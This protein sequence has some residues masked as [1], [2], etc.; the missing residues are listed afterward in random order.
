MKFSRKITL[1]L[2]LLLFGAS[3]HLQAQ[4]ETWNWYFGANAGVTF[5]SGSPV[6]LTNGMINTIEGVAS[7][8]DVN[9]NLLFYTDGITVW[10]RNHVVM[11]NGT[12]LMGSG[13]SSQS[14]VI[15][16]R[17]GSTTLYYIF[18][19][20]AQAGPG[21]FRYTEVDMALSGGFGSVTTKNNLL[22][23]VTD[24]K[25]CAV[26]HCNNKDVWV[27]SHDFNSSQFRV[28]LVTA[29]GIN[30][31]PVLTSVGSIHNGSSSNTLGYMKSSSDG[32]R[33]ALST[34]TAGFLELF[35]FNPTTGVPSNPITFTSANY[36]GCYGM[37][38]SPDNTKLYAANFNTKVIW[39]FDLCAGSSTAI[40]NSATSLGTFPNNMG[41]LQLGPDKKIYCARYPVSWLGV[42]NSPNTLG[43]GCNYV[44]NGV[45]LAGKLSQAGLPNFIQSYF[46]IVPPFTTVINCLNVNFTAPAVN[47]SSCSGSSTAITGLSWNFG[48]PN[49]GGSNTATTNTSSHTFTSAGTFSVTLVLNYACGSDTIKQNVTVT[50]CGITVTAPG[51]SVCS[52]GCKTI[53]ATVSAGT[54]PYTYTWNTGATTQSINP[55]P[56]V[57]TS[58]T[59]SVTDANGATASAIATLTVSPPMNIVTSVI[60]VKCNGGATGSASA[61][62]TGGTSPYTYSW[63]GNSSTTTSA[64]G[65]VQ[66]G[67]TFTVTDAIGCTK[68][69][70]VNITQPP[71]LT[72]TA[73]PTNVSCFGGSNG[74]AS[75][76]ANGGTPNY[77]YSWSPS[78]STLSSISGLTICGVTVTVTDANGC[79][80][81]ATA[82]ITQP[83]ALVVNTSS[84]PAT[85]STGGTGT[86]T[87]SGGTGAYTYLWSSG[88]QTTQTATNLAT[89]THTITVTDA[90]G[91]TQ[92]GTVNITGI[93][94]PSVNV[95]GT[96]VLCNG[97]TTGTASVTASGGTGTMTYLWSFGAQTTQTAT[98]LPQG[99]YTVTV[100]DGNGCTAT[101]TVLITEPTALVATATGSSAC[102]NATATGSAAGGTGTYTY[103]WNGTSQNTQNATG[104]N[105]GIYTLTV[106][107]ANGCSSQDTAIITVSPPP[108]VSFTTN[109]S[110]GCVA[111]CINL[112]CTSANIS[113]YT[114][115]FGDGSSNGNGST[116]SHC[117]KT[118]GTFSVTL[119]VVDNSGCP[120]S[121]TKNNYINV[122]PNVIA[123]FTAGPQPTTILNPTIQFTDQSLNGAISWNWTF[124]DLLN[125]VSTKQNPSFPYKD[126]GCYN[127][128]LIA[129]NQYNCPDT[130][131]QMVCIGGD[132]ELFAPNA[133][134]PDGN[135]L[136]DLFLP[137]GIG[138]DPQHFEMYIF[139]RWGNLIFKTTDLTEGWNGKAN[140]GRDI[141]QQ[142]VYVW[143]VNTRD[144]QGG[145][146]SYTGHVSLVR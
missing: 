25:C 28:Y 135:G 113:S 142:D 41:A 77:T 45:P 129:D 3:M 62:I 108:V 4:K 51:G 124:G 105:T 53:T 96:N 80:A 104:L 24:E 145:K 71:A 119:S 39:Q 15:V 83:P 123:A 61:T 58:Y 31:T 37:E 132:Y 79:T 107:D 40:I 93:S 65:L 111:L 70:S 32:K 139:D 27:L 12:G 9:G 48:D 127:V 66:G 122:Y 60:N 134:T 130:S 117:Y 1:F 91:C 109:D 85:C 131:D 101:A 112:T 78:G 99:T 74:A 106:T 143:K 17:P 95:S 30:L 73:T 137:R 128:R 140:G 23:G 133:F 120:G 2:S 49:S 116:V 63:S 29:A 89:G 11:T 126:S 26:R 38:F 110:A 35:D 92:T 43:L 144:F 97:G 72:V 138:I 20:D 8:S 54:S 52:G 67:Y 18:T 47:Q 68:T 90:N 82:T 7:I 84:T 81:T 87:V 114:W 57:T 56:T 118:A 13:S 69:A 125:S 46:K 64:T 86:V 102:Q 33:L 55:C 100:T 36:N 76:S 21:G 59:V 98:G 115:N 34:Y 141:A 19:T 22:W 146:H 44:D 42:I 88:S 75:A 121:L 10:N 6:A 16:P 103:S 14:G 136:N 50:S 94:G 5:A